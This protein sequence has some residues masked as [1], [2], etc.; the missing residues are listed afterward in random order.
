MTRH[1]FSLLAHFRPGAVDGVVL[2][3]TGGLLIAQLDDWGWSTDWLHPGGLPDGRLGLWVIEGVLIHYED[4]LDV[5]CR[6]RRPTPEELERLA[7]G[8]PVWGGDHG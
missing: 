8:V 4:D 6:W 1:P 3:A 7:A 2:V 5:S